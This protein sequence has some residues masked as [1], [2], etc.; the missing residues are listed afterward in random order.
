MVGDENQGLGHRELVAHDRGQGA[1]GPSLEDAEL[2]GSKRRGGGGIGASEACAGDAGALV[3][4]QM[5][6]EG[7]VAGDDE[8]ALVVLE[9][10]EADANEVH[11]GGLRAGVQPS[12]LQVDALDQ[13][14]GDR[15]DVGDQ[16]EGEATA[17]GEAGQ[18]RTPDAI[19]VEPGGHG[20]AG[21]GREPVSVLVGRG[22]PTQSVL[23]SPSRSYQSPV[24]KPVRETALSSRL[25]GRLPSFSS[26]C[27]RRRRVSGAQAVK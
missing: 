27:V 19:R 3:P 9:G 4:D 8:P 6:D 23:P 20:I 1:R 26:T 13:P 5:G 16:F 17:A 15:Q 7:D 24:V 25:S 22:A 14:V 18:L 11:G 21:A 12:R 10:E 2:G